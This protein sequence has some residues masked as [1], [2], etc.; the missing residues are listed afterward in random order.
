[1]CLELIF[2]QKFPAEVGL[3]AVFLQLFFYGEIE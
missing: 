3:P 2:S 1:M